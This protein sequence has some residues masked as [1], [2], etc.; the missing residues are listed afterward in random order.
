ML[1][2]YNTTISPEDFQRI[3]E[4]EIRYRAMREEQNKDPYQIK[5]LTADLAKKKEE[6]LKGIID[7][8]RSAGLPEKHAH[9]LLEDILA[10]LHKRPH[11]LREK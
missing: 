2:R 9:V 11:H 6:L 7:F 10:S 1:N 3:V 4:D 8:T 5:E